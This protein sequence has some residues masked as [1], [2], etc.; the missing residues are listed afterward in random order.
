MAKKVKKAKVEEFVTND[1]D[2]AER[3][4]KKLGVHPKVS[5]NR[6]ERTRKYIFPCSEEQAKE[7]LIEAKKEALEAAEKAKEKLLYV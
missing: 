7:L 4:Q 5:G 3:L 1:L 2:I 6:L